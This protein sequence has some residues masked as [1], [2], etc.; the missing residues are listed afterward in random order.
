MVSAEGAAE[1]A[2]RAAA[3]LAGGEKAAAAARAAVAMSSATLPG[4]KAAPVSTPTRSSAR[5]ETASVRV[6][7]A[8][9]ARW[10]TLLLRIVKSLGAEVLQRA[11]RF[12][13]G[14]RRRNRVASLRESMA[15]TFAYAGWPSR[16]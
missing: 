7:A 16:D 5:R 6:A 2:V 8:R 10:A 11:T 14:A 12:V 3:H 13:A 1:Q 9:R 15:R 4:I